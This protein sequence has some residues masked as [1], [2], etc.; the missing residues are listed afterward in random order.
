MK[1]YALVLSLL[2]SI[3]EL[4]AQD[5]KISFAGTGASAIVSAVTVENLTQGTSLNLGGTEI[6][7]LV[8]TN[9]G[10]NPMPDIVNALRIYPNPMTGNST[11]EFVATASGTT[12]I[13]LFDI[14][15]KRLVS[16]QKTLTVGTHSYQVNGLCSGIY[17]LKINSPAYS[18]TGK[19]VSNSTISSGVKISYLGSSIVTVTV[20][21]LKSANTEKVM[22]YTTGDRL[23]ITGTSGNYSTV[24]IDIPTHSETITFT[25]VACTDADGNNYPVVQIGTQI[26]MAENLK[27]T[28]YNDG[29]NIPNVTDETSWKNLTTP[30]YCWYN[31]DTSNKNTY[32]ALFNWYTVNTG[33]LC[34]TGWHVPSDPEWTTLTTYLGGESVAGGKMK[35]TGTSHWYTPNESATNSS[36]FTALPGGWRMQDGTFIDIGAIGHWWSST[37]N[38]VPGAYFWSTHFLFSNIGWEGANQVSGFSIR[39]LQDNITASAVIP[40]LSTTTVGNI[41]ATSASSGGN[42]SSDGGATVTARGV[43]WSTSANP[44]I[45]DSKT[46]DGSGTGS[47]TSNLTGLITGTLYYV[48][49]Y[50]T[51]SAGTAYGNEVSFTTGSGVLAIGQSYQ[52]GIIAYVLQSGDPGY[53]AGQTHGLIAA[54][55]DQSTGIQWFNGMFLPANASGAALGTGLVNTNSIVGS[56]G[57]GSYAAKLCDDLVLGGYSDWYL[58]SKEELNKLYLNMDAI[59]GFSKT[60][61]WSSSEISMYHTWFQAF[62][63]GS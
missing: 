27:T 60:L 19:L 13:E 12:N 22:Q 51:N 16:S 48:R 11:I 62:Y 18:Y 4:Q 59:G 49:S 53:I 50:A 37:E 63:N 2:L 42:I 45:A 34:P 6:L 33:K 41:T 1:K 61:Y 23:K 8:A 25:F 30:G 28:K 31:N 47:F 10:L 57:T 7:H 20:K 21:T 52:G 58:P 38:S 17:F 56:Q 40:T 3:L 39:C 5:Y 32:G 36:G 43:C 9:T 14:T 44:T 46:T 29:T 24:V 26:W 55:S 54:P 15:G 35:E